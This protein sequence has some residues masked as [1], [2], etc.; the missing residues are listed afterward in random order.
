MSTASHTALS[1]TTSATQTEVTST[2]T[3]DTAKPQPEVTS[4]ST[5]AFVTSFEAPLSVTGPIST[6]SSTTST[7]SNTSATS[8]QP[9]PDSSTPTPSGEPSHNLNAGA[10]IGVS[11]A[12]GVSGFFIIGVGLF[13]CCRRIRRK[14]QEAKN[15]DF[16]EI[17][18]VMSEPPDFGRP[19]RRLPTPGPKPYL[20][21]SSRDPEMTRLMSPFSPRPQVPPVIVTAPNDHESLIEFER[22]EH[23]GFAVSSES[24][25][26]GSQSS[27]RTVSDLLPDRPWLYPEPLRWGR[28]KYSRPSSGAFGPDDYEPIPRNFFAAPNGY[29]NFSSFTGYGNENRQY[30]QMR[31]AGLPANPRALLYG[32]DGAQRFLPAKKTQANPMKPV[33]INSEGK[34]QHSR[35]AAICGSQGSQSPRRQSW[36]RDYVREY[37][38]DPNVGCSR[39]NGRP[40]SHGAARRSFHSSGRNDRL[41]GGSETSFETVDINENLGPPSATRHSGNFKPLSP[42]REV[43]TPSGSPRNTRDNNHNNK[44]TSRGPSPVQYPKIPGSIHPAQEIVSRPRIVKQNDI[45]R[46]QIHRGKPQPK[47][48]TVPYSPEDYWTDP[49]SSSSSQE[50]PQTS[51]SRP[52]GPREPRK[53]MTPQGQ[54][55]QSPLEHNLTPSRRGGDLIIRVD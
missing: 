48:L 10:V 21:G 16:F 24:E 6:P 54:K 25:F 17:G 12:S 53:P 52:M 40:S 35:E 47:E 37:W 39:T 7:A 36:D 31:R 22:P 14:H 4:A 11:V 42:L 50:I 18:G 55:R 9:I 46:V 8:D 2:S 32:F 28:P 49:S 19:P 26:E 3:T 45:K 15:R 43:R 38:Q 29:T 51:P 34:S 44:S 1:E 20:G 5:S 13:F 30:T 27:Y 33:Y 23:I 41:S